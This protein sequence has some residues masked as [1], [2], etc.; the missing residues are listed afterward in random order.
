MPIG[1][2]SFEGNKC[3]TEAC[4]NIYTRG[5]EAKY[6]IP[7]NFTILIKLLTFISINLLLFKKYKGCLLSVKKIQVLFKTR[8]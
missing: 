2:G 5:S 7:N 8:T 3:T 1:I 6:L 4:R